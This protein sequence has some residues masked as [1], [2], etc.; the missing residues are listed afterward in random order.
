VIAA[1]RRGLAW[2]TEK[3]ANRCRIAQAR[4][5]LST[6]RMVQGA[7]RRH[8]LGTELVV[9]LTSYPARFPKLSLTLRCLLQQTIRPD[10]IVLWIAEADMALLPRSV[11]R[12][13]RHGLEIRPT[14][15]LRSFKKIVPALAAFP[16]ATIVTADDDLYFPADWLARLVAAWK[17][18]PDS[19]PCHRAHRIRRDPCGDPLPYREW[20]FDLS[21]APA[22]EDVFP[23]SGAGVLYPPGA[24]SQDVGRRELFDALCPHADDVWLYW[25]GRQR[26]WRFRKIGPKMRLITWEL[27]QASALSHFNLDQGGNDLQLRRVI[28]H[29]AAAQQPATG[30]SKAP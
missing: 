29:Y 8:G 13:V 4:L 17:Q 12:L 5:E 18:R 26:G 1:I 19:L 15:D 7:G 9:S 2:R 27:E 10:R 30:A 25:M 11:T 23:T 3:L 16:H 20:D 28:A 21:E 24:F 14:G 22:D 6:R